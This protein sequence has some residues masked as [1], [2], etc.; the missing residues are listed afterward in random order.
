MARSVLL[1]RF[2]QRK[3][4]IRVYL[5]TVDSCKRLTCSQDGELLG[6]CHW[7]RKDDVEIVLNADQSD[8]SLAKTYIHELG[9]LV[10]DR[11]ELTDRRDELVAECVE[12]L[13]PILRRYALRLPWK[14]I[15]DAKKRLGVD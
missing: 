15:A 2:Q 12:E 7:H 1:D 14:R 5:G 8:A 11:L 4:R 10:I 3:R 6:V 9:H 13:A